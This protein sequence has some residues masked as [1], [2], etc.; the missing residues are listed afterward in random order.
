[1]PDEAQKVELGFFVRGSEY[2]LLGMIS[3]DVHLFGAT[4]PDARAVHLLGADRN[5][6]DVLSRMIMGTRISMTIGLVGVSLSFVLGIIIGGISGFIGGRTDMV[7]QRIVEFFM[8]I[9]TMPLWLGL[10]AAIPRDW[11]PT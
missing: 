5:G 11:S 3:T 2:K 10:A 4:D 9:P 7:I 8:A 1:T 6:R